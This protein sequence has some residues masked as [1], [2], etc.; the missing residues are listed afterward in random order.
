M[1]IDLTG[2][3]YSIED[4]GRWAIDKAAKLQQRADLL[5]EQGRLTKETLRAYFGD[6]RFEQIAESNAIFEYLEI[7][8]NR[9]RRHSSLG[10]LTPVEYEIRHATTTAR[11]QASQPRETRGTPEPPHTSRRFIALRGPLQG[12]VAPQAPGALG[13]DDQAL[14]ARHGVRRAP[15]QAGMSAREVPQLLAQLGFG[16]IGRRLGAPLGGAV[17]SHL[18]TRPPLRD[19]EPLLEALNGDPATVRGHHFP[20]ARSFRIA[21]SSSA[22]A[23]SFFNRAFSASSSLNLRTSAAFMP[24]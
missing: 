2:S 1:T 4:T 19:P 18:P 7:F 13:V 23:S 9:Q 8:H 17:L 16:S 11:S 6:K 5:R 24:A 14:T 3:P 21:L 10:M 22:S 20:S 15:P 12:L